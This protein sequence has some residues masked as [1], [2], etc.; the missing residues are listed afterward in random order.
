MCVC[1]WLEGGAGDEFKAFIIAVGGGGQATNASLSYVQTSA[2]L[3]P[4]LAAV[5]V[6]AEVSC[7][8]MH[9]PFRLLPANVSV[10]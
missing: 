2:L 4:A 5:L 6:V 8:L 10:H 7:V 9:M 3:A 1:V